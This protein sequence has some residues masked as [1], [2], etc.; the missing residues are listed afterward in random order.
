MKTYVGSQD[1]NIPPAKNDPGWTTS[2]EIADEALPMRKDERIKKHWIEFPVDVEEDDN[3]GSA[4]SAA[5]EMEVEPQETPKSRKREVKKN[6]KR[7]RAIS[8][9]SEGENSEEDEKPKGKK[10]KKKSSG[11][12]EDEYVPSNNVSIEESESGESAVESDEVSEAESEPESDDQKSR[13]APKRL[14]TVSNLENV[15]CFS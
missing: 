8:S 14:S 6:H 12:N 15:N 11:D 2:C 7:I 13:R 1:A 3:A 10:D 5:E 4:K 9:S